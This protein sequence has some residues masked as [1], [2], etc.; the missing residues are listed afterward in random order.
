MGSLAFGKKDDSGQM[1]MRNRYYDPSTG[2]FTQ[3][4]PIGLAGGLN[5]YGFADGD[6]VNKHDPYGL[7]GECKLRKGCVR[8]FGYEF[9]TKGI[10]K[11]GVL[12]DKKAMAAT[13]HEVNPV[14]A[15]ELY[16][17]ISDTAVDPTML[18][19]GAGANLRPSADWNFQKQGQFIK[20][21][22]QRGDDVYI[23]TTIRQGPSV[24]KKEIRQLVNSGYKPEAQGSKWLVKE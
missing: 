19:G 1:Y 23:S 17:N 8:A 14:L 22:I 12:E 16:G 4:D 5:L 18:I 2:R 11:L 7:T 13:L 9:S 21:V 6:P 10:R 3:E 20:D 15:E 24:L